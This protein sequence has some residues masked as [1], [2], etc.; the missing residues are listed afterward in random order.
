VRVYVPVSW[1]I[2]EAIT[3]GP[4]E[5]A[6]GHAVTDEVRSELSGADDEELEY[7]TLGAAAADALGLV[8]S[9]PQRVVLAVDAAA[10]PSGHLSEVTLAE[11]IRLVDVAA[12]HVDATDAAEDVR[13]ALGAPGDDALLERV[14]DHELGWYA[15]QELP[16]LLG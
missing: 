12:V 9:R 3:R 5:V 1:D 11:P 16:D 15:V 7:A 8:T 10:T 4:V 14:L 2:L 13:A 6:N